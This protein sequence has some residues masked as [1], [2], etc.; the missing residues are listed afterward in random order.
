MK[1][2][3]CLALLGLILPLGAGCSGEVRAEPVRQLRVCADPNNLPY[4]N[5]S[6]EGF[7]NK[8]ARL[9]AREMN[10]EVSYTW[11][12][13]RRGFIRNTLGEDRCDVVMGIPSSMEM[14]LATQ[15]Y[16]R[17]TYVFL[18]RKDRGLKIDNLDDPELRDLRIGLH[19]IGDDYTNSP[20][21]TALAKRGMV[22]NLV[23]YSIYGNYAEENPPA[24]LVDAVAKGE[25]DVG[26][27]WGPIA[28][29]FAQRQPVELEMTPV[30]PQI[31]L[32]FVPFVYDISLGVERGDTALKEELETTLSR[33]RAEIDTILLRY[34]VPR[35]GARA[36]GASAP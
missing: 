19:L 10:A 17:S 9:L 34:G 5:Q 27:V 26:I 21:A 13:Q 36:P 8:L 33:N 14:A 31:D 24:R 11:W 2:I 3:R 29:Y 25:V 15:P 12:P 20:A 28:G 4:S 23:G 32:P 6:E 16:Y 1:R 35:V 7:E 18:T 22:D 30:T